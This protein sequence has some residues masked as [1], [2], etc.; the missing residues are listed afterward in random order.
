VAVTSN[1]L[2]QDIE[3]GFARLSRNIPDD[4]FDPDYPGA[5]RDLV[6]EVVNSAD[7]CCYLT[8]SETGAMAARVTVVHS[9]GKYSASFG[10]LSAFQGTMMAFLGEVIGENLPTFVQAPT[11]VGDQSLVSAFL[12]REVVVPTEAEVLT[13]FTSAAAGNLMNPIA[14]TAANSTQLARLCPIPHAWTA[15][16]LDSKSP[17]EAWATGA[18]LVA[19]LYTA[20]ERDR[21]EPS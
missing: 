14:P 17:F 3:S 8:V 18:S 19:T 10:A 1:S 6:D 5:M 20:D 15:Y 4:A 12:L 2:V 16:F 11:T 21:A 9:I 13:Y 7:L